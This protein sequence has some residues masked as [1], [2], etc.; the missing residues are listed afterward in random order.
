MKNDDI[1]KIYWC[2]LLTT[3]ELDNSILYQ[4]PEILYSNLLKNKFDEGPKFLND[5]FA[6]PSF[7][8]KTKR[9]LVFKSPI[10]ASYEY[11]FEN[12]EKPIVNVIDN[13]KPFLPIK[14]VRGPAINNNSNITVDLNYLFFCEEPVEATFTSPYF[15]EAKYLKYGA[16]IPGTFNIGSWFRPFSFEINLWN[17]KGEFIL[18]ENEPIFYVEILTD[19]KIKIERF[20]PNDNILKYSASC[21]NSTK[22]LGKLLSLNKRYKQFKESSMHKIILNEIKRN[23]VE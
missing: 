22:T 12:L 17:T 11:N 23:V 18:E 21:V 13:S 5:M 1:L 7:K 2:P 19:K 9:T 4:D 6:C 14:L 15:S 3:S 20:M 8:N 10:S 16:T